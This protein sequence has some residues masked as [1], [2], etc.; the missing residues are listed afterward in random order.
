MIWSQVLLLFFIHLFL[1]LKMSSAGIHRHAS[2]KKC[3]AGAMS[4]PLLCR[5][6]QVFCRQPVRHGWCQINVLLTFTADQTKIQWR[7]LGLTQATVTT[8]MGGKGLQKLSPKRNLEKGPLQLCC[9]HRNWTIGCWV[10]VW[11]PT[12][13]LRMIWGW[14]NMEFPSFCRIWTS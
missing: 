13:W 14:I 2:N 6:C 1:R 5:W 7:S 10:V 3:K 8:G 12:W 4:V 9:R 11:S